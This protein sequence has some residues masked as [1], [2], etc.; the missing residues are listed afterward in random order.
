MISPDSGAL[1]AHM[2]SASA[3]LA[4][5]IAA[6]HEPGVMQNLQRIAAMAALVNEFVLEEDIEPANV[7]KHE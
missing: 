2:H 6:S 5:P 1:R 3:M 7:F 4:L